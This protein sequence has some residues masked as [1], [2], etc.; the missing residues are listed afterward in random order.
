MTARTTRGNPLYTTSVIVTL[1]PGAKLPPEFKKFARGGKLD[2]INGKALDLPNGV[3]KKLAAHPKILPSTTIG[4]PPR[5]T[6]ARRSR[7]A[8]GTVQQTM[9]YT[10]AGIGVAVIDS[11][12]T[13]DPRRGLDGEEEHDRSLR[14]KD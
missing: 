10:G 7:S 6:I 8:C 9:G 4:R 1:V 5:T 14:T 3:L 13:A 11:G 12:V 2:I